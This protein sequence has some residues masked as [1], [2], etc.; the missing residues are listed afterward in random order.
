MIL[1]FHWCIIKFVRNSSDYSWPKASSTDFEIPHSKSNPIHN[2]EI[3]PIKSRGICSPIWISNG[4]F[5]LC[6]NS[7]SVESLRDALWW[8]NNNDAEVFGASTNMFRS[9]FFFPL[10]MF[11]ILYNGPGWHCAI[12]KAFC[13]CIHEMCRKIYA[14]LCGKPIKLNE[15]QATFTRIAMPLCC[16]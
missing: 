11:I 1:A 10:K 12:F 14:R 5:W 16:E 9:H 4:I 15:K 8:S 6:K 13:L 3:I 2:F 7:L